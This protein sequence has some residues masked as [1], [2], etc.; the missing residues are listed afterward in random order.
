M[1]FFQIGYYTPVTTPAIRLFDREVGS[2]RCETLISK[3][4]VQIANPR[5]EGGCERLDLQGL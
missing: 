2:D 1:Y 5:P 4:G 3:R